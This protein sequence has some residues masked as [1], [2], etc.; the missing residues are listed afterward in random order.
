[1]PRI[2]ERHETTDAMGSRIRWHAR[3]RRKATEAFFVVR[4]PIYLQ[5]TVSAFLSRLRAF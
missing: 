5:E 3:S 2:T 1:M 4:V